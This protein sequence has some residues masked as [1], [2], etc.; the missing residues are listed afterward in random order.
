MGAELSPSAPQVGWTPGRYQLAPG[1]CPSGDGPWLP[2]ATLGGFYVTDGGQGCLH[3]C[4]LHSPAQGVRC[5]LNP[6]L[7]ACTLWRVAGTRLNP[8]CRATPWQD[9]VCPPLLAQLFPCAVQL[10]LGLID[11]GGRHGFGSG[12][13]AW[14]WPSWLP[15]V[16]WRLAPGPSC[17]PGGSVLKLAATGQQELQVAGRAPPGSACPVPESTSLFQGWKS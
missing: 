14:C 1:Q 17:T 12:L 11:K 7:A 4:G 8:R 15:Q 16:G 10:G 2:L 6:Q 9:A 3:H 5:P 13:A